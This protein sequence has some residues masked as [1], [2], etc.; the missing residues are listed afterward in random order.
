MLSERYADFLEDR[1]AQGRAAAHDAEPDGG[2]VA[3]FVDERV[4]AAVE[5]RHHRRRH[6]DVVAREQRHRGEDAEQPEQDGER[7]GH[8]GRLDA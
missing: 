6:L 8:G 2:A 5:D 1:D 4:L 3:L 7:D